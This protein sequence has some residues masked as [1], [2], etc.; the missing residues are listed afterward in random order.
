MS[1]LD[2]G[3]NMT[4]NQGMPQY[5]GL[6][7]Q[8]QQPVSQP[9][10]LPPSLM[11]YQ[12]GQWSQMAFQMAGRPNQGPYP[13]V[14]MPAGSPGLSAPGGFMNSALGG[15]AL[16]L[17][18]LL[19]KNPSMLSGAGN[20]IASLW[21]ALTGGSSSNAVSPGAPAAGTAGQTFA[22]GSS[23]V[24]DTSGG[25]TTDYGLPGDN[26]STTYYGTPDS[27]DGFS[28]AGGQAALP[29]GMAP[30]VTDADIQAGLVAPTP[31]SSG[32][33]LGAAGNALG[34]AGG[35][36]KGGVSGDASAAINAG[37]LANQ[38]GLL[39]AGS[40]AALADLGSGLGIYNGLQAGG[41]GGDA[42]AA[43]NAARLGSSV[44][45]FGGASS[46]IGDA[47][48]YAAIPLSLYN[49]VKNWQS[50]NTG[51]DA[52]GGAGTGAAIGT[53]IEPGIGTAIG[54][55]LGALV[56]GI[57]S[58]F[59]P[60]KTDPETADV[61]G[62]LNIVGQNPNQAQGITA[63][64]QDPYLQLAGLMDERS[65]TLPMYQQYGRMGEQ[66][67]T[68]A[69]TQQMNAALKA[70][71]SLANNPSAMYSQVIAPWVNKMGS[72]YS[73]VGSTYAQTTQGLLQDMVS[74][75]LSGQAGQDWKAVGG[76]EPFANIYAGSPLAQYATPLMPQA[77][78][79]AGSRGL[80]RS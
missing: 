56:G 19:A 4:A 30:A 14:P 11:N 8:P 79:S 62:L 6:M 63:Q 52:L 23:S 68:D 77:G 28:G 74:Q 36:Q 49:E 69:M 70:N 16:G 43:V 44:G 3:L 21:N 42:A 76:Q 65:S 64:V 60:G 12:P 2:M 66:A 20:G 29:N 10:M 48:G 59:G 51:G 75:Y 73:Q 54:A 35:L 15:T 26:S 46:A 40:N 24:T 50:G 34:I 25:T 1:A 7:S 9:P 17:L 5:P 78:I 32:S 61:Q 58:A 67:F 31:F 39:P 80:M 57:S 27:G 47:A 18:G 33:A 22:P 13:S 71:P 38:A 72:G 41:V 37:Q 55:G 45:A 53:A